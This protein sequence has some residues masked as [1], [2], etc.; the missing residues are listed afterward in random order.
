MHQLGYE[1]YGIV[2]TD[3]GWFVGRWMVQD[4]RKSIIGHMT[5]FFMVPASDSDRA[6]VASGEATSEE[7]AYITSSDN[8]FTSHWA[9]ATTHGQKP[10]A[11]SQ[12]LADSPVGFLGWSWD[13]NYAT[14]DG[15]AYSFEHLIRDALMLWIPGPYANIRAYLEVFKVC[16]ALADS[17]TLC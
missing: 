13:I 9:Y 7:A 15:Y 12:A 1:K 11:L 14:S 6:R 2:T 3:L 5:D 10:L 4:V 17:D 8:W 16:S